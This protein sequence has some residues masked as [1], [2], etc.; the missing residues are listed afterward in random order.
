[1][2]VSSPT[3][4]MTNFP[5]AIQQ[6]GHEIIKA[7]ATLLI[8]TEILYFSIYFH[9]KR[10]YRLYTILTFS[11]LI[12]FWA[13]LA[14]VPISCG[15]ARCVQN[16][17]GRYFALLFVFQL[18]LLIALCSCYWIHEGSWPLG[19]SKV[20]SSIQGQT[21]TRLVRISPFLVLRFCLASIEWCIPY[22]VCSCFSLFFRRCVLT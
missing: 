19:S 21:T 17:V 14:L 15:P 16:F 13:A 3:T 22:I 6:A 2:N 20:V 9:R 8:P 5:P 10:S 4:N 1:M 18:R 11:S 7:T 12:A